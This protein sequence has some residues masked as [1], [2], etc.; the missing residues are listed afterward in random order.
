MAT[1]P[2]DFSASKDPETAIVIAPRQTLK[3]FASGAS[4]MAIFVLW[5]ILGGSNP[6]L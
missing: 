4:V 5:V 1:E 3:G 6:P 2:G